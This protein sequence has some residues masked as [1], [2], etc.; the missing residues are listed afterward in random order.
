MK[1]YTAKTLD[2]ALT[3]AS[4]E[5][6]IDKESLNYEIIE[7][8][9][10][11]FKKSCTIGIPELADVIEFAE[12][13]IKNVCKALGLEPSVK[14]FYRDELIKILIET[15]HN[16]L[17]IGKNGATLQSLNELTKLA[18]NSKYKRK[19]RI[20]L[21]IGEYKDK[22]Y[23]RVI[24]IAKRTAREVLKTH[25]EVKDDVVV[26]ETANQE[27]V[28]IPYDTLVSATGLKSNDEISN[29]FKDSAQKVIKIGDARQAK[30]IFECFHQAWQAIR[31]L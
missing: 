25:I 20:L 9:K 6:G 31:E 10:G 28:E 19:Y 2:D 23:S 17:L 22:K 30:K 15:D 4:T 1:Q 11:L 26:Y 8:K 27:K 5:L 12:N 7:E 16:S 29:Q 13:Y 18:V 24:S 21:D 3:L 14:T